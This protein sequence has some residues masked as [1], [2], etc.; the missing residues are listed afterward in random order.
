MG[1]MRKH[2][3]LQNKRGLSNHCCLEIEGNLSDTTLEVNLTISSVIEYYRKI[4]YEACDLL[5]G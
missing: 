4:Y 2:S 1:S 5:S 3:D